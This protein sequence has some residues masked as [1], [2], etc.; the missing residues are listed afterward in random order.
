MQFSDKLRRASGASL[1]VLSAMLTDVAIAQCQPDPPVTGET[2]IC[3]GTDN[4]GIVITSENTNVS[5]FSGARISSSSSDA[6]LVQRAHSGIYSSTVLLNIDGHVEAIGH[7]GV[8]FDAA[9][10]AY[11]SDYLVD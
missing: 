10:P 2:T 8:R 9:S 6:I 1:L 3:D 5:L 11:G 7:V 4:S